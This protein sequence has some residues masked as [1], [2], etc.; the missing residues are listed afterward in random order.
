M[1][2]TE[3][4]PLVVDSTTTTTTGTANRVELRANVAAIVHREQD[5]KTQESKPRRQ[6]CHYS[7]CERT[8]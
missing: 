5:H 4:S 8:H 1:M 6:G 3:A 2:P 7:K